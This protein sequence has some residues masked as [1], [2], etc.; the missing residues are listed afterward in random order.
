MS[1]DPLQDLLNDFLLESR[2]RLERV[3]DTLLVLGEAGLEDRREI[4]TAAKR[5]LHTLKGNSGMM[6]FP[7]LQQLA[8]SLE[9]RVVEVDPVQPKLEGIL[10]DLDRFRDLLA[11]KGQPLSPAAS[12]GAAPEA[13]PHGT[14]LM[15]SI[16][17]PFDKLDA[18]VDEAAEMVIFRNR[19]AETVHRGFSEPEAEGAWEDVLKAQEALEKV[20]GRLQDGLMKLRMVPLRTLFGPLKRIVHDE[21]HR[22]GKQVRFEAGGGETPMDKALLEVASEALGHIVRNAVVHA[23]EEPAVRRRSGKLVEGTVALSA[24]AQGG[25]VWIDVADDGA[26][27]DPDALL[28]K[29][30]TLG[31]E[32]RGL[33]NPYSLLFLPDFSTRVSADMS[34]GRGMGLSAVQEA[35]RRLGGSVE[36]SSEKGEGTRFHLSLPLTVSITRALLVRADGEEYAFPLQNI[37]ET[38]ELSGEEGHEINHSGV[39]KWRRRMVPLLDLGCIFGTAKAPRRKGYAVILRADRKHRGF[40]ADS[41][42]GSR[43]IV[44]KELDPVVGRAPGI[45]G[46]TVLGDGRIILIMDPRGLVSIN[47]SWNPDSN[48]QEVLR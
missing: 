42:S 16:R 2:E 33:D 12:S 26:G 7:D 41:I 44:V 36:V 5:E 10:P 21:A 34:S 19:L 32:T 4:L 29:A 24:S 11:S 3:Q 28:E 31:I 35:V 8:H 6:G 30:R 47:P 37:I 13:A 18:L 15:N 22:L 9:D 39:L 14:S 20:L 48:A 17:I 43:E 23:I 45:S 40:I 27:I 25:E 46:G 1:S 38:V